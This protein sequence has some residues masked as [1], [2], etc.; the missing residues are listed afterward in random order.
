MNKHLNPNER[1]L[2][3]LRTLSAELDYSTVLQSLISVASELTNSEIASILKYDEAEKTL[4]F[5]AAPWFHQDT[6]QTVD[7]PLEGSIA[8]WVYQHAA[9]LV[10]Q[11]VK[12]DERF[13]ASVDRKVAFETK[14][15]IAVPLLVK[16]Q[17]VGVFEAINKTNPDHYNGEDV[18]ILETLAS[19]AALI[20]ENI[21]L[22]QQ[23]A[24]VQAAVDRLEQMKQDFIAIASHEL[25]TPLGLILGHATFL[26]EVVDEKHHEQLD[27]IVRSGEKLKEIIENLSN[28]ENFQ[29]G[30]ARIRMKKFSL[31]G[32][33]ESTIEKYTPLAREK[34]IRIKTEVENPTLLINGDAEKI[35]IALDNLVKNAIVFTSKGGHVFITAEQIPGYTKI[36][37]IDDGVGI[38][39]A[40]LP[41]IFERFYQVESHLTR[42]YNGMGLG[43]SVAKVMIE[44]HGGTLSAESIPDKGSQFTILLPLDK[45]Q[46]V[47]AARMFQA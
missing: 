40:D 38:S 9:P 44:L 43:L 30:A 24:Q 29:S 11:N 8:G 23:N 7:V 10:L 45:K 46:I 26:R 32:L 39:D 20:V 18:I 41:H 5:L 37:V 22:K 35:K 28:V 1:L 42:H 21:S 12:E 13:Y 17:P 25:R 34:D 2:E 31:A 36:A 4:R 16:G 47:A 33:I 14:S 27:T 6:L 3:T 19:H 15:I